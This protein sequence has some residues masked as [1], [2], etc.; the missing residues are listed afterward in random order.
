MFSRRFVRVVATMVVT[1]LVSGCAE[2]DRRG[3]L[4][5]E[6]ED[7]VLFSAQTKSHR[8]FRSYLL[9]GVLTAAARHG[10]HNQADAAAISG[11]LQQALTV[12]FEAYECLYAYSDQGAWLDKVT[13]RPAPNS[14]TDPTVVIG[15]VGAI[16]FDAPAVCQFFDEKMARLDYALY[17]LALNSLLNEKTSAQLTSI[18]DKLIG[19]IPVLS[20]AAKAAIFGTRAVSQASNIVDDLLNLSFSSLGPVLTLLPLYRD[21]LEMNMWVIVD[22]L[23]RTCADT[24]PSATVFVLSTADPPQPNYKSDCQTKYYALSIL[25]NGNGDLK[26]WRSFVRSM[27][28]AHAVIEAYGPHFALVSRLIWRSCSNL[29]IKEAEC[30]RLFTD[31]MTNAAGEAVRVPVANRDGIRNYSASA[32][33]P[34][35]FAR[36]RLLD[37]KPGAT[38]GGRDAESTG[39]IAPPKAQSPGPTR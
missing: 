37:P 38:S 8:L 20:P 13:R 39:S 26:V 28:D 31:A 36:Q 35:R 11:S 27:N 21:S 4:I 10:G 2:F 34:P 6:A 7:V 12:A 16:N 9:I 23:T 32:R 24:R 17:R 3:G 22:N 30:A 29:F 15:Q 5:A 1:A 19:E 14:A 33:L 18:G 25:N